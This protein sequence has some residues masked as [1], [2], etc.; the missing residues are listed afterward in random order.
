[1][2]DELKSHGKWL[3]ISLLDGQELHNSYFIQTKDGGS[4]LVCLYIQH[5]SIS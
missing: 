1:M 2:L 5:T 4:N 3:E